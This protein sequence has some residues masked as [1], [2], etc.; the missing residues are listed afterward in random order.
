MMTT[1]NK[2]PIKKC[3]FKK[4][5]LAGAV[6]S[7]MLVISMASVAGPKI[8]A[9]ESKSVLSGIK[10]AETINASA[11]IKCGL[12]KNPGFTTIGT[13]GT[14]AGRSHVSKNMDYRMSLIIAE[15][16]LWGLY[17]MFSKEKEMIIKVKED[18]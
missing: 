7:F 17:F 10:Q 5:G 4:V 18:D 13:S 2:Q 1:W 16:G 12:A 15:A 9:A 6:L 11:T 8:R 14:V 3:S